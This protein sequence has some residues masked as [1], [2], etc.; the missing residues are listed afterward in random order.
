MASYVFS[1]N[2]PD[3]IA[4][5]VILGLQSSEAKLP[6][7]SDKAYIQRFIEISVNNRVKDALMTIAKQKAALE[8]PNPGVT[9]TEVV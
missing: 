5:N 3:E 2:L 1:I 9:V 8:V 7:E 4:A 6:G